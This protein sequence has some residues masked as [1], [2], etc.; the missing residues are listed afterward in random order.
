MLGGR[1]GTLR[2]SH[3]VGGTKDEYL[4]P[5]QQRQIIKNIQ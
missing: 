4:L 2:E 3:M 5:V 1:Q